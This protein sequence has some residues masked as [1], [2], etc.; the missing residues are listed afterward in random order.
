[1]HHDRLFVLGYDPGS[2]HRWAALLE[3]VGKDRPVLRGEFQIGERREDVAAML[4]TIELDDHRKSGARCIVAVETPSGVPFGQEIKEVKARGRDAL[5][6]ALAAERFASV[7]WAL[8]F[9]VEQHAA[10]RVRAELCLD[11]SAKD[12]VVR[13]AL[14]GNVDGI[15][16]VVH[17]RDAQAIALVV[18]AR[19]SGYRIEHTMDLVRAKGRARERGA[20]SKLPSSVQKAM[21]EQGHGALLPSGGGGRRRRARR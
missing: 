3:F 6:T 7:A 4:T 12:A 9:E 19:V 13:A 14:E 18:G 8:G 20:A 10:A 17:A 15:G 11:G 1:M 2:V 16:A 5:A 21:M